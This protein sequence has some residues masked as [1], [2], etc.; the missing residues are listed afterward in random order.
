M[1]LLKTEIREALS[2]IYA[3]AHAT[4]QSTPDEIKALYDEAYAAYEYTPNNESLKKP[5][6]PFAL[7]D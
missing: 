3:N 4:A 2:L 5:D 6:W 7:Q 1:I